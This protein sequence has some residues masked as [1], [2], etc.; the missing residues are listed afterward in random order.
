V[1]SIWGTCHILKAT[2]KVDDRID[3]EKLFDKK[4][5]KDYIPF[6]KPEL[7]E[8]E[9]NVP[10]ANVLE[11]ISFFK[12]KRIK[13][14]REAKE[15]YQKALKTWEEKEK[16]NLSQYSKD[17]EKY[18]ND[19]TSHNN[20]LKLAKQSYE[21]GE[22]QGVVNYLNLVL[23]RSKYP[24]SLSLFP[25]VKYE[26]NAKILLVDMELP[27]ADSFIPTIEFKYNAT[28]QQI[29][30][31]KMNKKEFDDFYNNILF[32]ITLRTIH[33]IFESDYNNTVN[34]VVFNGWIDR[35]NPKVG[36][37][38]RNCIISL[39]VSKA[40]FN[41]IHLDKID[42]RECFRHLKGI[43]A[44]SLINLSPVKPI[45]MLDTK[46]NRFI[47][48]AEMLG[49]F[50]NN[51]N[52]ASME[53]QDFEVLIR[54]LIQKE[55]SHEGCKVEVTRA[56]RDA[57]V[58]AI[59]FDEDPIRGGK[60]VVQAK[61]YNNLVPLSAVRDLYGTVHNEGA[62]KGILV[63]TSYFGGDALEFVKDK[64]LALINGEQLLYMFNKHG[65]KMKIELTKKQ[66]AASTISY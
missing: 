16:S 63:T 14:E 64:P 32:Q 55:F 44:G 58:D 4:P 41:E 15:A 46:D 33:E 61:R 47:K 8:F 38:V 37:E 22:K 27:V 31:R 20:K 51:T 35:I 7:K 36:K 24:S 5:F 19:Q 60:Y 18:L 49:G 59:A 48:A 30:D 25:E 57:G 2:L 40:E 12:N 54:D 13:A 10:K 3:W 26:E 42:P 17:K 23:E 39:Q 66:R 34:G 52:L 45:M 21:N 29:V 53:W 1:S 11:V 65:Y 62:V 43:T 9:K 56:S 50:D 28:T 6:L